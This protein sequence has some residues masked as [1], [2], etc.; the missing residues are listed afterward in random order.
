MEKNKI[1]TY[2]IFLGIAF[3]LL[4]HFVFLDKFL[5]VNLDD[6]CM[7]EPAWQFL[8]KGSFSAPQFEG[9]YGLEKIDIYH[10]RL[11]MFFQLPFL[12]L[13]G[14]GPNQVRIVSLVSSFLVLMITFLIGNKIYGVTTA[15]AGVLL[16]SIS[17]LFILCSH[18]PRQEM[19]LTLFIVLSIYLYIIAEEKKNSFLFF[20]SGLISALS[21]DVHLNGI[22][23]V[24][25]LGLL[26]FICH[27]FKFL[28]TRHFWLWFIGVMVGILWWI[29]FHIL[30]DP[31]IF[32]TQFKG[33]VLKRGL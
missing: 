11:H 20:T 24:L 15:F 1:F 26:F 32:L 31:Q 8:T 27:K 4:W 3:Y 23:L 17:G 6:G 22:M 7:M 18:S 10:G 9:I 2:C 29:A 30:P 25:A 5:M 14:P 21:L 28:F 33:I 13:F 12:K 19:L 16:L